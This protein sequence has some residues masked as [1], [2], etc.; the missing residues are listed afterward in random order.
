MIKWNASKEDF[1]KILAIV[2]RAEELRVLL[3]PRPQV[4][5]DLEACHCNGCPLD[6][7]GLLAANQGDFGHDVLGIRRH[8][9]RRT[10]LL[11]DCFLPRYAASQQ[12]AP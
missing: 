12:T 2:K 7:D 4:I 6:L 10:G 11:Q 5:M 9:N 3:D 8:L 1:D